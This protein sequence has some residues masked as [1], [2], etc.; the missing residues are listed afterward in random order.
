MRALPR[1]SKVLDEISK[2]AVPKRIL[3]RII[4]SVSFI[5]VLYKGDSEQ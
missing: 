2:S 1:S 3:L 5:H 4:A